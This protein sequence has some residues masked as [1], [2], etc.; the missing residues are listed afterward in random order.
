LDWQYGWTT[1]SYGLSVVQG[2]SNT[3]VWLEG[4]QVSAPIVLAVARPSLSQLQVAWQ[5]LR[6]GFTHILPGGLDHVLFVLGLFLLG[7]GKS[8]S[9]VH[10]GVRG[11]AVLLQV[12]TFTVA[13]SLT[14]ALGLLGM[15]VV[16]PRV[17]EP[18]IALSIAY[19]AL[20]N[21]L[22]PSLTWRRLALVFSFGLLHG[23]G[24]ASALADLGLPRRAFAAALV[25]FNAGVELGQLTVVAIAF[26]ALG[27]WCA[28][29]AWYRR[30]VVIPASCAIAGIAAFWTVE[31]LLS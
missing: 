12:T 22:V 14:L 2:G 25:S 18:L 23:L 17:V 26:V 15:V 4:D 24:F 3:T 7:R 31:R 10:T 30:R 21:L 13:H 6:L 19:V 1:A 20:E 29:R 5:Y 11:S 16:S 27:A 8:A 28:D 9:P